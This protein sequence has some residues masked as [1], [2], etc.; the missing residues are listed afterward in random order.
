MVIDGTFPTVKSPNPENKEG[1]ALAVELAGKNDVDLIIGTD[2]DADRVGIMLK[3]PEGGYTTLS[4]NQVG[5]LLMD[6]I[7]NAHKRRGTLP[8][9]A[10]VIKT[11]VTT[12]MARKVASENGVACFETFTGFKFI[13]EKISELE[14]EGIYRYIFSYEESYGYLVGDYARDKDAVTASMMIAE[15]AAYYRTQGMTLYDAMQ[16]RIRNT[17]VIPKTR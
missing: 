9:N 8:E 16:M 14:A 5:V 10:A 11:V 4:G 2:P 6:Y 17:A 7:I 12:E 3:D 15:M 1:F 13:A